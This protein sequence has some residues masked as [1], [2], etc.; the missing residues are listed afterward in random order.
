MK[1][2]FHA[3]PANVIP[4]K[5]TEGKAAITYLTL[6][7]RSRVFILPDNL[8]PIFEADRENPQLAHEGR[9]RFSIDHSEGATE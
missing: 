7:E 2:V 6:R 5:T 8:I 9:T 4:L 3:I 1:D